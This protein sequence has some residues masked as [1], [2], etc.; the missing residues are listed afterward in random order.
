MRYIHQPFNLTEVRSFDLSQ[1]HLVLD[2]R[3]QWLQDCYNLGGLRASWLWTCWG[4][5]AGAS[6]QIKPSTIII[7]KIFFYFGHL[8]HRRIGDYMKLTVRIINILSDYEFS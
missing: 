1:S 5:M 7:I 4:K 6:W 8:C 2:F 3:S